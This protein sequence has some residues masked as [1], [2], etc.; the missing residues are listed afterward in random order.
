MKDTSAQA[1]HKDWC[2]Q[3][4]LID[5][6]DEIDR[7]LALKK[8]K[9]ALAEKKQATCIR[10]CKAN[11]SLPNIDPRIVEKLQDVVDR[12]QHDGEDIYCT[13]LVLGAYRKQPDICSNS[14]AGLSALQN[15]SETQT[16]LRDWI[17]CKNKQIKVQ[18]QSWPRV[19]ETAPKIAA[20]TAALQRSGRRSSI[21][22]STPPQPRMLMA[23]MSAN[24]DSARYC[25]RQAFRPAPCPASTH[26]QPSEC[27]HRLFDKGQIGKE[28]SSRP[29]AGSH[30]EPF[31]SA[32]PSDAARPYDDPRPSIRV[33]RPGEP[34][35]SASTPFAHANLLLE[36]AA[37]V[38]QRSRN[39]TGT[40]TLMAGS[41]RPAVPIP[42]SGSG[43]TGP[44]HPAKDPFATKT[45]CPGPADGSGIASRRP[46]SAGA[47]LTRQLEEIAR[48][49]A[50]AG[51]V[52]THPL[53][54]D[55]DARAFDDAG[56]RRAAAHAPS[57]ESVIARTSASKPW[58]A[59]CFGCGAQPCGCGRGLTRMPKARSGSPPGG[60]PDGSQ[61]E[62]P[63]GGGSQPGPLA[64]MRGRSFAWA[65]SWVERLPKGG[66]GRARRGGGGGGEG[67]CLAAV[68][69]AV[70]RGVLGRAGPAATES[71]G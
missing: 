66:R 47:S 10:I 45:S 9:K 19:Q 15:S 23:S 36:Q 44:D 30:P 7:L 58:P 49:E 17:P 24:F 34:E 3:S 50:L 35:P 38:A 55:S 4:S 28:E 37:L 62:N 60:D 59:P 64:Q 12:G 25:T 52:G 14:N 63:A 46:V 18:L 54:A 6:I 65:S 8:K 16:D 40:G 39:L 48:I 5:Q 21:V 42:P 29:F 68:M 13:D 43:S 2:I 33:Y 22:S 27:T 69:C 11:I 31:T 26:Y 32:A 20:A 56:L 1:G 41:S 61:R 67:G 71:I 57:S 51:G 70:R 53:A